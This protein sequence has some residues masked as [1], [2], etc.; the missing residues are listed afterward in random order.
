MAGITFGPSLTEA[1][2]RPP[3]G[4]V[5][6]TEFGTGFAVVGRAET[7]TRGRATGPGA[8]TA[9]FRLGGKPKLALPSVTGMGG[10]VEPAVP[11]PA[12]A[13]P[14]TPRETGAGGCSVGAAE[15]SPMASLPGDCG[16]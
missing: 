15:G 16:G 6:V 8:V 1:T 3:S 13:E 5:D 4:V 9:S 10:S 2:S 12:T 11:L 7:T 14:G